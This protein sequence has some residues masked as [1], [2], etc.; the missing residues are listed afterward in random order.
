MRNVYISEAAD[1]LKKIDKIKKDLRKKLNTCKLASFKSAADCTD[2]YSVFFGNSLPENFVITATEWFSLYQD[3]LNEKTFFSNL[4]YYIGYW[5]P[6]DY[7]MLFRGLRNLVDTELRDLKEKDRPVYLA[8]AVSNF[9]RLSLSFDTIHELIKKDMIKPELVTFSKNCVMVLNQYTTELVTML[10]AEDKDKEDKLGLKTYVRS[11]DLISEEA[12]ALL[13]GLEEL[14]LLIEDTYSDE[15]A[16]GSLTEGIVST[17][18]DRANAALVKKRR[19]VDFMDRTLFKMYDSW[20][21]RKETKNHEEMMGETLKISSAIKKIF[22]TF[23]SYQ[24]FGPI[25]AII[26]AIVGFAVDK[27]T[28][29][30]DRIKIMNDIKDEIEIVNEK[31]QIAERNGDDKAKIEMI[32]IR[33]KLN[34]EYARI[35]QGIYHKDYR[36]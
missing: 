6:V 28:S 25:G 24:I 15:I 20:R 8:N 11:E 17:A 2:F 30:N 9:R 10:H 22:R 21:K 26:T 4:V 18:K 19:V 16:S 23:I 35:T 1:S 29:K 36:S 14:R 33:Q 34:R 13:D 32:R 27:R 7:S 31:I 12:Q 3:L 5:S